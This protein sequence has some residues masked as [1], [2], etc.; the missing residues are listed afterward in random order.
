MK[1][2][3]TIL[4]IIAGLTLLGWLAKPVWD[5][6]QTLRD[7][8]ANINGVLATLS[9]KKQIQQDLITTYNSITD[10]QL[11][12]LLNQHLPEKPDTGTML[13][14]LERIA[15]VNNVRLN[16]ID[17]KKIEP[18][19]AAPIVPSQ[20]KTATQKVATAPYQEVTF[21]FTISGSYENFKSFLRS[22]EKHI[23]I[24]DVTSISFGASTKDAYT[25][26][27]AAKTY[28]RK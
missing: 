1:A 24:I 3:A 13:I 12:R 28:Y 4:M 16:S 26:T 10:A 9:D 22:L 15:A 8:V 25:F 5:D 18:P 11:D 6:V 27:L 7:Q 21:S 17:F 2:A 14:A 19:R 20:A 23:R